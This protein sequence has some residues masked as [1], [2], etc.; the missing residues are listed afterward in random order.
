[1]LDAHHRS[2]AGGTSKSGM[3]RSKEVLGAK[4]LARTANPTM[5]METTCTTQEEVQQL[6]NAIE[7][8]ALGQFVSRYGVYYEKFGQPVHSATRADVDWIA[9]FIKGNVL[10][11]IP[12]DLTRW[13]LRFVINPMTL[14][15]KGMSIEL[16]VLK[17][18]MAFPDTYI[19]YTPENAKT[20]IVRVYTRS[21]MF[22]SGAAAGDMIKLAEDMMSTTIRGVDGVITA[23]PMRLIRHR[24]IE[25]PTRTDVWG[26]TTRGCNISGVLVYTKI[27]GETLVTNV[28]TEMQRVFGIEAARQRIIYELRNIVDKCNYRHYQIYANEMTYT[29]VVTNVERT[30]LRAREPGN[31]LLRMG[32]SSPIPTI[33]EAALNGL[34][35]KVTGISA[36][37]L[38]GAV[39]RHGSL[40]SQLYVN[41]GFV[42]ANVKSANTELDDLLD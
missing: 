27:I 18:R 26:I 30:G 12:G 29:G 24:D 14:M 13:C 10:I 11:P 2:A 16:I 37:L 31:I 6:C 32:F 4:P 9:S 34:T 40:Y 17:L 20:V 36:P 25:N 35:D 15:L 21:N 33:E 1:M 23:T 38:V 8:M 22:K 28:I 7:M 41:T 3:T 42:S 5:M 19:M 39:P